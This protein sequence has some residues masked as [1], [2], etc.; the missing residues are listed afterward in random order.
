MSSPYAHL[1][2]AVALP[3]WGTYTYRVPPEFQAQAVPGRRV[4]VPFGP[5]RVTGYVLGP[6]KIPPVSELKDILD[7]LDAEALFTR[8]MIPFFSL[9][10]RLL[11]PSARRG[12]KRGSARRSQFV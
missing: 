2:I 8:D 1:E 3:V 10:R 12:H 6:G 5:R 11:Y 4:L 9:D 7:V